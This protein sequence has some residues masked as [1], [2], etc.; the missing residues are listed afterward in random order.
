MLFL[1]VLVDKYAMENLIGEENVLGI[2]ERLVDMSNLQEAPAEDFA[3]GTCR[4]EVDADVLRKMEQLQAEQVAELAHTEHM[5]ANK[6]QQRIITA[7]QNAKSGVHVISGGPGSGKT[8]TIRKILHHMR[9]SGRK[10]I[11]SATSG[12]A[13]TRISKWAQTVHSAF[14]I[15]GDAGGRGRSPT[16]LSPVHPLFSTIANAEVIIIDEMS[17]LSGTMF[18]YVLL[19]LKTCC[20]YR[21]MEEVFRNKLIILVGDHCQLPPVCDHHTENGD[22]CKLCHLSSHPSWRMAHKHFLPYSERHANDGVLAT[23]LNIIRQR[24]PTQAEIDACFTADMYITEDAAIAMADQNTT[25]LCTHV[26]PMADIND[27]VV[28]RVFAQDEVHKVDITTNADLSNDRAAKWV[29]QSGF[30]TLPCA[31]V[32]ARVMLTYNRD[33]KKG[34]V[35]GATGII[36]RIEHGKYPPSCAYLGHPATT[37]TG[38]HVK[39]DHSGE[40]FRV[41]RSKTLYF[42][43]TGATRYKKSTFPLALA[44]A[45]TG[46]ECSLFAVFPKRVYMCW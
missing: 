16:P 37:I 4:A 36:T 17:M 43:D 13:A 14:G 40:E 6:Y 41:G 24:K 35:N 19:R 29:W 34:A 46:E 26:K 15:F 3:A 21:S 23:F 9:K 28:R 8:F 27:K 18:A 10:V 44:Y 22:F 25:V 38:I 7:L 31:A 42:Y 5:K 12:P 32:G 30:H 45:I 11:V 1:Q 33:I 39:L 20:G 2:M